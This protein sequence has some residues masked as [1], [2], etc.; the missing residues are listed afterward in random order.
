MSYRLRHL[1]VAY[2][3]KSLAVYLHVHIS[4]A[5]ISDTPNV[6]RLVLGASGPILDTFGVSEISGMGYVHALGT[7]HT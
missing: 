3:Y 1:L 7:H 6:S 4:H 2:L 5:D